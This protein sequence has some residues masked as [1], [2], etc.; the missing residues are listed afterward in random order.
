M[1]IAHNRNSVKLQAKKC[2]RKVGGFTM[3]EM[4]TAAGVGTLVLMVVAMIF[5]SSSRSFCTIGNYIT[6][7]QSSRNALDQMT[8][9]IRASKNISFCSSNQVVLNFWSSTNGVLTNLIYRWDA[10]TK[11]LT[12]WKNVEATTNTLLDGCDWLQFSMF[13]RNFSNTTDIARGKVLSV[14][15]RCS[16]TVLGKKMTTEDMQEAQIVMRNKP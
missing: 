14:A 8:K 4:M 16:Q 9:D 15:W 5:S 11:Q 7:D 13:D 1:F 10:S 12:R 2:G 6:M 3:V